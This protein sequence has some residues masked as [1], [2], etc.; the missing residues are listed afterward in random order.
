MAF[1]TTTEFALAQST[2]LNDITDHL[3]TIDNYVHNLVDT[4]HRLEEEN[5]SLRQGA[6][7]DLVKHPENY[8]VYGYSL[9]DL[10]ALAE[11]CAAQAVMPEDLHEAARSLELALEIVHREF[12]E[13]F[14]HPF[15]DWKTGTVSIEVGGKKDGSET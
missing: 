2:A 6:A 8:T 3:Y 15:Y 10:I 4:I 9:L 14:K 13:A 1:K 12:D 5:N 11:K 7:H